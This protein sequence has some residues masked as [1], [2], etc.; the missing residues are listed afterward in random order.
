MSVVATSVDAHCVP[1]TKTVTVS[2]GT[3]TCTTPIVLTI[4]SPANNTSTSAATTLVQGTA[5]GTGVQVRV[6]NQLV[7]L[8]ASGLFESTLGLVIGAN[9]ITVEATN[10]DPICTQSQT[11][12]ISRR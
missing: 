1:V 5:T 6:N 4:S 3:T 12:S 10:A 11:L 8:N 2:Y 7:T 9:T